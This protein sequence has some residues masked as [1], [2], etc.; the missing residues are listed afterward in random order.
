MLFCGLVGSVGWYSLCLG[1]WLLCVGCFILVV[2]C[3]GGL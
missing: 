1:C 2:G 3:R